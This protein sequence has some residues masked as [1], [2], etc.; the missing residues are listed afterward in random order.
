MG[1]INTINNSGQI[2]NNLNGDGIYNAS[3]ELE[4]LI[5]TNT[6]S[7]NGVG[8]GVSVGTSST[9][10]ITTVTNS[11]AITG[12]ASGYGVNVSSTYGTITTLNNR[13]GG[14]GAAATST[15]L[16]YNGKLP[17]NYNIIVASPT[18]YGQLIVTNPLT[19][20]TTFG[21][22]S[23]G[24]SGVA[25]STLAS[26]TYSSVLSGVTTSNIAG[27]RTGTYGAYNWT[28]NNVSGTI[29]DLVVTGGGGGGGGGGSGS[30]NNTNSTSTIPDISS[31]TSVGLGS[32]GVTANPVLAGGTIV[33]SKGE[34]SSQALSVLSSG[35]TIAAP[36]T[37]AAQL[38]GV[39]SGSGRLTFSGSGMTVLSGA[40]T[41]TGGTVVDSG[42]LSLLGGTLGSGDVYVAS[43]AQLM[44][45]GSIAG[46]ITVAGLFKPG[47]S[48]GYIGTNANVTMNNGS[49]YQQ[50]IAGT[51]Q[52]SQAS[53]VGATGYYSYLNITGGQ[54]IINSGATLK[55]ALSNLF[56][57]SES[58]YGSTP[59]TPVLGDRFRIVTADGGIS[60]KFS[61]VTQPAELSAGTQ[62]L[63]FYNVNGSNSIDLAL[64]PTSYN[65]TI[66][67][68][69][70]NKNAQSIGGT[71]D[72]M[73]VASQAGTSNAAQDQL[74]YAVTGQNAAALPSY[75]QG[76]SGEVY[77]A[78]VATIAQTTQRVQQSV[79]N[80]LGDT[81]G[82]GLPSLMTNPTGNTALMANTQAAMSGGVPTSAVSTNPNA[83][84]KSFNNG[85]VWG[86]LAYQ[87]A[88]R[89]S[90]SY[91][92]GWNSNLYQLVFGS[93]FYTENGMTVGGGLALS[94]TNL[95]PTYGSAT[96][97]QGSIFAYG[98]MPVQEFVV[99]GMASI[100]L[101]SSDISRSDVT[102]LS[103]GFRNKSVTGNDAMVSLGLSRPVDVDNFR[104]TPFARVTWQVVTQSSVNEGDAASALSVKGFT[105]NGVRGML[106][107]AA[108]SK[109]NNPMTEEF[110][111]R[112]Y[113][114]VGAD[115]S[116]VLN[117]TLNA[118]LAGMSTNIT[119]PNAGVTFV[120]AGL[121]GTAKIAG[122][123]Y[124]Y[125]GLSGEVRSGQTLG[126]V[127]AGVRFQ[128]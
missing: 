70:G 108:G 9:A 41:Y 22:Y 124:A 66:G 16:S 39:L 83:E 12:G 67:T 14:N 36:T 8:S 117:P 26:G 63:T 51:T 73:V 4:N 20:T 87:K 128:F 81:M 57:E 38:S 104:I 18:Q 58:G 112:A 88:N 42:T 32:I 59:Y 96:I 44:G 54:F 113:V 30:N 64:I 45:T 79:L 10:Y 91:S 50:D 107:V 68:L 17:T 11:G 65:T 23:G 122:N 49:T 127:N 77:A 56:N 29:W 7:G 40:N 28:L 110:T 103:S 120:Q 123:A 116:G 98:K 125:I 126:V 15:A 74:L 93:D 85:N 99:D 47:N 114:G 3:G 25:A 37:G 101:N 86:D 62:F 31:G 46:S 76:L 80:R 105:G 1:G 72:K 94:N 24:V 84:A 100:G 53:P 52:A 27:S 109:A 5:N 21:I 121:Y 43:G 34:R 92:G 89:S 6:V 55:P 78:S 35:G 90:D 19:S 75:A 60:G 106:G 71:L 115:S 119:T 111:Y 48:P 2:S 13:Q 95:N 97:Q 69:S 118:S 102:G 33:L 82:I 61:N